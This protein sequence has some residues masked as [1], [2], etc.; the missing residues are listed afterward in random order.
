MQIQD[1]QADAFQ[2]EQFKRFEGRALAHVRRAFPGPCRSMGEAGTRQEVRHDVGR[3]FALGIVN[4]R[5]VMAYVDLAFI[6]GRDFDAHVPWAGPIL[7]DEAFP[8]DDRLRRLRYMAGK[9]VLAKKDRWARS[10]APQAGGK[11]R[12]AAGGARP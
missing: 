5:D 7:R 11:Q 8:P 2:A 4:E 1:R 9:Q 3:A 12:G 10:G 6:L